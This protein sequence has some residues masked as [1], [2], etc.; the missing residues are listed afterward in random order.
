M[1]SEIIS[2]PLFGLKR[3]LHWSVKGQQI[4]YEIVYLI[5]ALKHTQSPL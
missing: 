3:P 4:L 2:C 5:L 1:H